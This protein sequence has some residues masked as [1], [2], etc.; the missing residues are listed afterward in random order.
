[1]NKLSYISLALAVASLTSCERIFWEENLASN[2][3][4]E[5]FTYGIKSTVITV[6]SM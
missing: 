3:P 4:R 5:N 2:D 1:M 6:I